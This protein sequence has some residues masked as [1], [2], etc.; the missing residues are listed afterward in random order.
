MRQLCIGLLL[1]AGCGLP[2]PREDAVLFDSPEERRRRDLFAVCYS[3]SAEGVV[4]SIVI[5]R[6]GPADCRAEFPEEFVDAMRRGGTR[7]DRRMRREAVVD[8][9]QRAAIDGFFAGLPASGSEWIL[10]KDVQA[11]SSGKVTFPVE[12]I[13][14]TSKVCILYQPKAGEP[15][16]LVYWKGIEEELPSGKMPGGAALQ[17]IDKLFFSLTKDGAFPPK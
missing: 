9:T 1:A 15:K 6:N 12:L 17:A 4:I 14:G 13:I 11:D 8:E 7:V 3:E 2:D 16:T 10:A 5:P